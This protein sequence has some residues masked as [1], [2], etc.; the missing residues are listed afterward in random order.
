MNDKM[1]VPDTRV[2]ISDYPNWK[3]GLRSGLVAGGVIF[4]LTFAFTI[5]LSTLPAISPV[6]LSIALRPW[7]KLNNWIICF[8]FASPFFLFFGA[9]G[10]FKIKKSKR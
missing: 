4:I 7:W 5:F 2:D 1:K 10:A 8:I 6:S 3:K 9:G